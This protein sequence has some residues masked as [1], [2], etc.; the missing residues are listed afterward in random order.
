[1]YDTLKSATYEDFKQRY[2][3]CYGWLCYDEKETMVVITSVKRDRVTFNTKTGSDFFAFA[4]QDVTFKFLP[5]RRGWYKTGTGVVLLERVPARQYNRGISAANTSCKYVPFGYNVLKAR[6]LGV[7]LLEDVFNEDKQKLEYTSGVC[8]L[9]KFF[10]FG[11]RHGAD[12]R[13]LYFLDAPVGLETGG[14]V[15]FDKNWKHIKQE[16][17]DMV[18]RQGLSQNIKE[19]K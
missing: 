9:S 1:M 5:I 18:I 19:I 10:C 12:S 15:V 13:T 14:V 3:G 16:F 17:Q 6:N 11:Y 7:E 2:Q 4:D 8:V